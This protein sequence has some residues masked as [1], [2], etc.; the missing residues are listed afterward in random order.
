AERFARTLE[1]G[2]QQFEK[3]ASPDATTVSGADGFRLHDTFGFPLDLTRDLASARAIQVDEDGFAAEMALQ[4]QRSR[5]TVAPTLAALKDV[6]KS[7]FTGYHELT[8]RTVIAGIRHE[9]SPVDSAKEGDQIDLFLDQT[10][11]Y[12]ESGG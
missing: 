10:P 7:K 11:F 8:T 9:G 3:V 2:M 4:R 1:E 12:A 6:P 5:R